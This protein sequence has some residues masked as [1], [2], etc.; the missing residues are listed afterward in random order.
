[1]TTMAEDSDEEEGDDET[2]AT[3]WDDGEEA[4]AERPFGCSK[5]RKAMEAD[6]GQSGARLR[7]LHLI[8]E[9]LSDMAAGS[10]R[11]P[12]AGRISVSLI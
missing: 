12:S 11:Q 9:F 10:I 7:R 4:V 6:S 8:I 2:D 5:I 3:D 1:M